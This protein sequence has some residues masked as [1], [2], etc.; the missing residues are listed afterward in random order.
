[1]LVD[2]VATFYI[3]GGKVTKNQGS[4]SQPLGYFV[5]TGNNQVLEESVSKMDLHQRLA[6][7]EKLVCELSFSELAA[8]PEAKQF[9]SK[10]NSLNLNKHD[11]IQLIRWILQRHL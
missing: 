7:V 2:R 11:S 1:M 8:T 5:E 9:L 4:A 10:V 6:V 3:K